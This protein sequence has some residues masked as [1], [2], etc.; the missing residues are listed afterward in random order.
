MSKKI[1]VTAGGLMMMASALAAPAPQLP[2][3]QEHF[4]TFNFDTPVPKPGY[5]IKKAGNNKKQD[6]QK[7]RKRAMRGRK[8]NVQR[9]IR[10]KKK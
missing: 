1:A 7:K 10:A 9:M 3:Q 6:A 2:H 8:A 5:R 4:P